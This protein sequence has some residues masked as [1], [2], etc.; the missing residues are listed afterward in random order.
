M[1]FRGGKGG[2]VG[3]ELL[4]LCH[5]LP[6]V[7]HTYMHSSPRSSGRVL[8]ATGQLSTVM[9]LLLAFQLPGRYEGTRLQGSAPGGGGR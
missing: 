5:Q 4:E 7:A 1:P 2:G 6:A 8:P 9:S 3:E